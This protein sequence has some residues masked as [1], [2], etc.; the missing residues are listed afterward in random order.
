MAIPQADSGKYLGLHLDS[1][2]SVRSIFNK[3]LCRYFKKSVKCIDLLEANTISI[4]D[5][6]KM[7]YGYIMKRLWTYVYN[8]GEVPKDPT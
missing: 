7:I 5:L 6:N 3:K 8:F 1:M 2:L 4:L